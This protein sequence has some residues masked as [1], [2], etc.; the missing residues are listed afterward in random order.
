[1]FPEEMQIMIIPIHTSL[2]YFIRDARFSDTADVT[3]LMLSK[4][5]LSPDE[6]TQN[7][8]NC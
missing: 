8:I 2:S 5:T 4:E 1:M 3:F 6:K 7:A